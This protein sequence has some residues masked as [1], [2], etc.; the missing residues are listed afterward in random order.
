[1][2]GTMAGV[3]HADHPPYVHL[4]SVHYAGTACPAGTLS[5]R[6][7]ENYGDLRVEYDSFIAE[8]GPDVS[9]REKRKNC[10]MSFDLAYPSGWTFGLASVNLRGYAWLDRNVLATQQVRYYFQGHRESA[11]FRTNFVGPF[12]RDYVIRDYLGVTA[13]VW[14]PC[15]MRRALS[16]NVEARLDNGHNR[17]GSGILTVDSIDAGVVHNYGLIWKRCH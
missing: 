3:A 5:E 17:R 10:S 7:S 11:T 1:M 8:V 13:I 14:A 15:N 4:N 9:V 6:L 16:V 12:D 2:A